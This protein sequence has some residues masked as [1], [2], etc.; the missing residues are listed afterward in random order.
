MSREGEL[1]AS[2]MMR[3][4]MWCTR[5]MRCGL[6]RKSWTGAAPCCAAGRC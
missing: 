3:S 5:V 4:S 2:T 1:D 6:V